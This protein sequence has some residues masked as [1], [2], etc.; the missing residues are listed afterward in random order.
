VSPSLLIGNA[1]CVPA[2]RWFLLKLNAKILCHE[3]HCAI[4]AERDK[5]AEKR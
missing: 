4:D 1:A 3:A 5:T 2:M